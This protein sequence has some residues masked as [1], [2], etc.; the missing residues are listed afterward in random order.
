MFTYIFYLNLYF[1]CFILTLIVYLSES[2]IEFKKIVD[3][4]VR[5]LH[6]KL[7]KNNDDYGLISLWRGN[8]THILNKRLAEM[9]EW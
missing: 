6:F 3:I 4:P 2:L 7:D 8:P 5:D 1:L 9:Y